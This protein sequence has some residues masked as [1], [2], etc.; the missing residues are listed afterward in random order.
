[1]K[2]YLKDLGASG[3]MPDVDPSELPPNAWS[4]CL[5]VRFVNGRVEQRQG[6]LEVARGNKI[7]PLWLAQHSVGATKYIIQA[8][9]ARVF[10]SDGSGTA[11]EITG[12]APTGD[13]D[14]KWTGGVLGGILVLTN[15]VDV[16]TYWDG[17]TANNLVTL[18][19][20]T[21]TERCKALR[22]FKNYLVA[23]NITKG[24][25][26][27]P[28]MVKWS[29]SADPGA[30]PSSWDE[31]DPAVDAGEQDLADTQDEIVDG[32]PLG[33]IFVIYKERS[34]YG[35][36]FIGAPLIWRFFRLPDNNQGAVA[37]NCVAQ[38]PQGHVVFSGSDVFLHNGQGVR[39]L[40]EGRAR[41]WLIDTIDPCGE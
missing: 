34:M 26:N 36:Q 30:L 28:H 11:T 21:G 16:P 27:Y 2:V 33:D 6:Y 3:W 15:G 31:T 20:W 14:D 40:I 29:H 41:Q 7:V 39:S 1:M 25:T 5:N 24:S 32:L 37:R 9:A 19:D 17:N 18:T 22:P 4:D 13:E 35:M 23:L 10:A 12:T 38:T 8:C